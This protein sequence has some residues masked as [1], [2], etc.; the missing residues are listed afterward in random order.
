MKVMFTFLA[1]LQRQVV[2]TLIY[3]CLESI[4]CIQFAHHPFS[5]PPKP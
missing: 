3:K 2:Q 4:H 5:V 1:I